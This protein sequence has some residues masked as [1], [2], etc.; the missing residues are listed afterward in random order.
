ML[1]IGDECALQ[2][3]QWRSFTSLPRQI[4]R[5]Y[6]CGVNIHS[7]M[8]AAG[9]VLG[10]CEDSAV[11][12]LRLTIASARCTIATRPEWRRVAGKRA[13]NETTQGVETL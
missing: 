1:V 6:P 11:L 5:Y 4:V 13:A 3:I 10:Q 7:L 12:W 9:D 8:A 2:Y